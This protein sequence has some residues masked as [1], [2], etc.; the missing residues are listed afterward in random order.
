LL[1][2]PPIFFEFPHDFLINTTP[3]FSHVE[4]DI[5]DAAGARINFLENS[6]IWEELLG[7][8]GGGHEDDSC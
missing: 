5:N 8:D 3:L 7:D 1:K 6:P 4:H 2:D